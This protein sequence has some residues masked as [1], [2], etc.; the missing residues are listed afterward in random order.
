MTSPAVSRLKRLGIKGKLAAGGL[1]D[2]EKAKFEQFLKAIDAFDVQG[3]HYYEVQVGLKA[4]QDTLIAKKKAVQ[5]NLV[6]MMPSP[7]PGKMRH[8]RQ[9]PPRGR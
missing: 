9:N 7:W 1:S 5:L 2:A 6:W 8:C 4:A 3:K